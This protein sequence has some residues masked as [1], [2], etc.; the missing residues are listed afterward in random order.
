MKTSPITPETLAA[1]VVAVPPLAR[2][3]DLAIDRGQNEKI[4]RHLEAGGVRTLLYGGNAI[5]YHVALGEYAA[6]LE[7][8]AELAAPDTLVIP[9]VG[10]AFGTMMDQAKL[11]G[12]TEFPTAMVLPQHDVATPSGIA[13]GIRRFAEAFGRPVVLYIKRDGY[14]DVTAI[15]ALVDDGLVS[16]IKY[17]VVRQRTERDETLRE[18]VD[19]V[20]ADL[21]VSGIGEQPAPIHMRDFGL[22]SFTSGCVCIAPRLSMEMLRAVQSGD[23]PKAEQIQTQFRPLEDLRNQIHPISVLHGAVSLAGIAE[24]GPVLPLLSEID[25]VQALAVKQAVDR[26]CA[27]ES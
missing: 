13:R 27:L 25:D 16:W 7:M 18:L 12:Q 20:A 2:G 15:R 11:L 21:V 17:A 3:Q 14:L 24:T 4:I 10:P 8:L 22:V 19:N 23:F 9:S 5:F 26:L 1:S 6:L